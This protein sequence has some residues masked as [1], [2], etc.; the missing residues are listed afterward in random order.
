MRAR[1][2]SGE[3]RQCK[4][5][6]G[7][8]RAL[9][10]DVPLCPL[11]R[12]E[13]SEAS[14]RKEADRPSGSATD[15]LL[16]QTPGAKKPTRAIGFGAQQP[17]KFR[18]RPVKP[19]HAETASVHDRQVDATELEISGDVLQEIDELQSGADVVARSNELRVVIEPQEAENEPPDRI[20]RVPAV[21][22]EI[23]PAAVFGDSLIHSVGFDQT[24]ERLAGE[25][26]L[27]DR[28][29]EHF[30]H[31]PRRPTGV[32]G[33]DLAL[34]LVECRETIPLDLVAEDVDETGEAVDRSKVWPQTPW[35]EQ[36]RDGEVL[37][38]RAAGD[39]GDIHLGKITF[40]APTVKLPLLAATAVWCS[41]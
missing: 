10:E 3:R 11:E 24:K 39:D 4:A 37:G 41:I 21:L 29:L 40:P 23:V 8:S 31:G 36:R 32:A 16:Q 6:A 25:L 14:S 27:L 1:S 19:G 12:L 22:T 13:C 2:S 17:K 35:E 34:E 30:H 7:R 18:T 9:G 5:R 20:G 28:R 15:P 33:L 38:A 26:E